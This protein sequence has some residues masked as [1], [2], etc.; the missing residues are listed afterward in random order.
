MGHRFAALAFTDSVREVQ[1]ALGSRAGYAAM[2]EGEDYSHVLTGREAAFIA[3]R[4]SVYMASVSETGWPYVQHRGGPAGFVRVLDER[5]IGFADFRGNRQYVSVGNLRKDDRVALIFVDYPNRTRL[6]LLGR[7]R[8]VGSGEPALLARLAVADARAAVERG[9]VI[10]IEAFDWNC[11][12][13]ITPRYSAAEVEAL[14]APLLEENRALEAALRPARAALPAAIGDGPLELVISGVRQLTPRVRAYEL[15]DPHG[16]ALPAAQAG[17]HLEVPV[18]Y[19]S[20][21]TAT[22]RYSIASDPARRDAYEIAVLRE[23]AGAGGSRAVHESFAIGLRLRCGRPRSDFALH[24]DARPAVLIAGGIGIT[25]IKA[26]A[27]ALEARGAAAPLHYAVR[28]GAEAAYRDEL[29]RELGARLHL[30]SSADGRRMD[31]AA[32]LTA[33]PPEALFYACGPHR[34]LDAVAR[35]AGKAGIDP[36]RVRVERFA[37]SIAPDAGPIEVAL[38]RSGRT[39]QVARDQTILDAALAAGVEARY[40]CR[41]GTCGTCAVAVLE[42]EPDHRDRVLSPAEREHGHLMC[43]CISRATGGRLVLDL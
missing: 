39:L 43:P 36:A 41:A 23:D 29:A 38:R 42:G 34:L 19:D 11:P 7:V 33:A 8:L 6:K 1:R 40:G 30:Y 27:H 28:S 4:D 21:E 22:R 18:R 25:P 35:C 15:R 16:R 10:G 17:A 5:T 2:D 24:E 31:I 12:R 32:L 37:A 20:G 9:F 26:M 3:A 14:V 13:H